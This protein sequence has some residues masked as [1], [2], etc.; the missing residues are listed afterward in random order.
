M[1]NTEYKFN[2]EW[3]KQ[4]TEKA[5]ATLKEV[6]GRTDFV[7]HA[8][9]IIQERLKKDPKCYLAYGPYWWALKQILNA[10]GANI[11]SMMDSGIAKE[12]RGETDEETI[13]MAEKFREDYYQQFFDG[14]N[15]F[16]L[17][18]EDDE[19]PWILRDPDCEVSKY[20]GRFANLGLSEEE[21]RD[22]EEMAE[23]FGGDYL[24]R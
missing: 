17:D 22:W 8:C 14:N 5:Q 24:N 18:P 4:E 13:M 7:K 11:G 12:Y 3:I 16:D 21:Q 10:N 9:E 20:K 19:A 23:F 15:Q 2:P 1:A 6:T